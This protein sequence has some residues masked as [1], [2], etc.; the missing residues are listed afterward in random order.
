[1]SKKLNIL[2]VFIV[3]INLMV[4]SHLSHLVSAQQTVELFDNTDYCDNDCYSIYR[5]CGVNNLKL[6]DVSASFEKPNKKKASINN[7]EYEIEKDNKCYK[8]TVRGKKQ[9]FDNVDN[10]PTINGIAYPEFAWWNSTWLYRMPFNVNISSGD[11]PAGFQIMDLKLNTDNVPTD[12]NWTNECDGG[13]M[14]RSRLTNELDVEINWS[15]F[16]C[17]STYIHIPFAVSSQLNTTNMTYYLYY[18]NL[19]AVAE[20]GNGVVFPDFFDNFEDCD[21]S[22]WWEDADGVKEIGTTITR[23]GCSYYFLGGGA[24][25]LQSSTSLGSDLDGKTLSF[26]IYYNDTDSLAYIQ[27]ADSGSTSTID[28]AGINDN[29]GDKATYYDGSVHYGSTVYGAN[30]WHTVELKNIDWTAKT[31]TIF[32]DGVS[33]LSGAMSTRNLQKGNISILS[34]GTANENVNWDN[35]LIREY[36][37]DED[38]ISLTYLSGEMEGE[39]ICG[40]NVCNGT[41]S[42]LTCPNDCGACF[43]DICNSTMVNYTVCGGDLNRYVLTCIQVTYD[44]YQFDKNNMIYCEQGCY[45]GACW[46]ANVYNNCTTRCNENDTMCDGS[47][48]LDCVLTGECW[49]WDVE[50]QTYCDNGCY[51]GSCINGTNKCSLG[52]TRC[53]G[54]QLVYCDDDNKDGFN[55]YSKINRTKCQHG[56]RS[57]VNA[58]GSFTECQHTPDDFVL[59]FGAWLGYTGMFIGNVFNTIFLQ[60]LLALVLIVGSVWAGKRLDLGNTGTFMIM[61]VFMALIGLWLKSLFFI[62]LMVLILGGKVYYGMQKTP[63]R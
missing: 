42:C 30:R 56:C 29:S 5:I 20:A 28:L 61:V 6:S 47:F 41:E 43:T 18:N 17:N 4:L 25:A 27:A 58:S 15:L 54:S 24:G 35:I 3:L 62:M 23:G 55:E 38:G 11:V 52:D 7:I 59:G 16:H 39:T 1:M 46:D 50:N 48:S 40:D 33:E 13:N 2:I 10:I 19:N 31:F 22:D 57:I 45:E 49:N 26:D 9:M 53:E 34:G 8:F 37:S 51:L 32:V 21:E 63:D 12:W 36:D 44:T 14:T 60:G